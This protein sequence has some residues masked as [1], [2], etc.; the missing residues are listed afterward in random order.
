MNNKSY[1]KRN[2]TFK[3]YLYILII[4]IIK[5]DFFLYNILNLIK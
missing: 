5:K 3:K 2:L 4:N 1:I